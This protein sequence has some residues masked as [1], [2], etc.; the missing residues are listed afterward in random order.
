MRTFERSRSGATV[1]FK[2]GAWLKP[3]GEIGLAFPGTNASPVAVSPDP[4]RTW[5]HRRLHRKLKG[6]IEQAPTR[7][8]E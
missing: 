7:E 6:L 5:G 2:V 3:T 1:Y 8:T 4:K